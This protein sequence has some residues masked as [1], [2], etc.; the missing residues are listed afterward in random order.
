MSYA[1]YDIRRAPDIFQRAVLD[2]NQLY[3]YYLLQ[4]HLL[5]G[6][7]LLGDEDEE[8]QESESVV[9]KVKQ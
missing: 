4:L 3:H 2:N 1:G 6:E 7:G 8:D 5:D 9:N